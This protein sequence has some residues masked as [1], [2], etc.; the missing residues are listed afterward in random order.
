MRVP[1]A[2]TTAAAAVPIAGVIT[3]IAAVAAPAGVVPVPG[4]Q[5]GE[6]VALVLRAAGVHGRDLL[7]VVLV[8]RGA[9]GDGGQLGRGGALAGRGAAAQGCSREGPALVGELLRTGTG[10]RALEEAAFVAEL[11]GREDYVN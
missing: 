7:V 5:P 4:L 3:P 2:T 6:G 11:K 1:T 8:G 9:A 10:V